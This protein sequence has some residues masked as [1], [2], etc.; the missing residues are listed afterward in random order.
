M[1]GWMCYAFFGALHRLPRDPF[2]VWPLAWS[3]GIC[4]ICCSCLH[5]LLAHMHYTARGHVRLREGGREGGRVKVKI[6]CSGDLRT[7]AYQ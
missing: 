7:P 6:S 3:F 4:G 2:T 1:D 5:S